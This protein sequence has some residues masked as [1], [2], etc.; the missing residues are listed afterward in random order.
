MP[1]DPALKPPPEHAHLRWH[2]LRGNNHLEPVEWLTLVGRWHLGG[3]SK[4]CAPEEMTAWRYH[5]PCDPAATV[6]D[7]N[8]P[9]L[10]ECVARA[11]ASDVFDI[12]DTDAVLANIVTA[13]WP[14]YADTARITLTA[15]ATRANTR[16][17]PAE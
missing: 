17:P 11:L 1:D 3:V 2:W 10:V 14:N 13:Q 8:D 9:E 12:G 4:S 15:L 7:P 5:G 6:I 16:K